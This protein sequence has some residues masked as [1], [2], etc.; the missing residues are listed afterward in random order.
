ML[1]LWQGRV[2]DHPLPDDPP[3][4][5]GRQGETE[6]LAT[7][8]GGEQGRQLKTQA[9]VRVPPEI[10]SEKKKVKKKTA[11]VQKPD[12]TD[13]KTKVSSYGGVRRRFPAA[14]LTARPCPRRDVF[15]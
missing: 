3:E 6:R 10:Q 11:N 5:F 2:K 14:C 9:P 12:E 7:A 4:P 13:D 8:F 1:C 15:P